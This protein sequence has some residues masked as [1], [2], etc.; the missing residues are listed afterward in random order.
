LYAFFWLQTLGACGK[1][2]FGSTVKDLAASRGG[3][4]KTVLL[5]HPSEIITE[6][7]D[8]IFLVL[9]DLPLL[10]ANIGAKTLW[11]DFNIILNLLVVIHIIWIIIA[12]SIL[13]RHLFAT[14]KGRFQIVR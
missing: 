3:C 11:H 12:L 13:L 9:S 2:E 8:L 10:I 14:S 4:H 7:A 5:I 1:A 6:F